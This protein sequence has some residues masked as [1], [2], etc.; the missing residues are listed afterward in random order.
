M[1]LQVREFLRAAKRNG[2]KISQGSTTSKDDN[3]KVIRAC[4]VGTVLVEYGFSS[5]LARPLLEKKLS[6]KNYE[7]LLMIENG[8]DEHLYKDRFAY[9]QTT[10]TLSVAE[11]NRYYNIGKKLLKIVRTV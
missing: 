9:T 3:N 1:K 2:H 11:R 10:P 6:P 7:R 8:F 5:F 4:A